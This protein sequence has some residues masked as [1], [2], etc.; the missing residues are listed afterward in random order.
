[1]KELPLP[2]S[3]FFVFTAMSKN[4]PPTIPVAPLKIPSMDFNQKIELEDDYENSIIKIK[5]SKISSEGNWYHYSTVEINRD[6]YLSHIQK[7]LNT[8]DRF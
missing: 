6:L 7:W 8:V 2:I 1:M 4:P 3:G 5:T